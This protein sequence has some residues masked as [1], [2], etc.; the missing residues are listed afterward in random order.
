MIRKDGRDAAEIRCPM[1][2]P[3]FMNYAEG[4]ALITL[5]STRVI[6]AASVTNDVPEFRR[7]TGGGWITAEYSMLPRSTKERKARQGPFS[8]PDKRHIEISRFI[9]R[10]LRAVVDI[11]A[12]GP[13][14]IHID[15]DVID[16]DAGTRVAAVTG[17]LVAVHDAL[18][19]LHDTGSLSTWPLRE[20]VAGIS[21]ALIGDTILLDPS[22]EEDRDAEI[23]LSMAVT[24]SRRLVEIHGAS[25]GSPYDRQTL[26]RMI[27][28]GIEGAAELFRALEAAIGKPSPG[29]PS[30]P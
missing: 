20:Y 18:L 5:G 6:C 26:N 7:G 28:A 12:L 10:C 9:G 3:A 16:A 15:C 29:G 13:H 25:E 1:I 11:D 17:S 8:P 19:W 24:D 4:S 21:V 14:L 2:D 22:Y 23:D 30:L 27:D